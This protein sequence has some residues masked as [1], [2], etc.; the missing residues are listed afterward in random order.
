VQDDWAM[1]VAARITA[2]PLS[3]PQALADVAGCI[4][5]AKGVPAPAAAQV[6]T[7]AEVVA[8]ALLTGERKAVLLGNAAAQHPQAVTLLALARWIAE[9]TGATVGYLTADAN[10]VGAQLVNALPGSGGLNAGQMLS[11][12]M[13]ALLLLD[14]EPSLDSANAAAAA[15]AMASAGLVVAL[16]SFKDAAVANADVLL[17]I[18]PFTETAGTF[19]NAEGR[20]Q[21]FH[22][23]V[24]PAGDS[25][26]A[27]KV[28]R[29][30]GNL[31]GLPGFNQETSEEVRAEALGDLAT[32]AQRL[33]NG[34]TAVVTLVDL[35]TGL[36]RLA[37][38]PIYSADALVRH[39]ASLQSTADAKAPM[40]GLPVSLWHQLGMLAGDKVRV[41][42]GSASAVL[43]ARLDATLAARTV[44]VPAGHP[45]TAV[46][47]AMFGDI[48]VEKA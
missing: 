33:D 29:V 45:D 18:A 36:Q 4:A 44:R 37:D 31:L 7:D 23:V 8:Q 25:R 24:K 40:V 32:V 2:D 42:Q 11:Q 43:P 46:L 14:V 9:Q 39:A 15:V 1:P 47:G 10:T 27:W 3:W 22:G 19:V 5:A 12:P 38:V 28:L 41:T 30:L 48:A 13:K 6:N 20:V 16:T 26:P 21:R 17:P 35:P 34:S